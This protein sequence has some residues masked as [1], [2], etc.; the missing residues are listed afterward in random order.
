MGT[1]LTAVGKHATACS[2]LFCYQGLLVCIWESHEPLATLESQT[3]C[4]LVPYKDS[5][6]AEVRKIYWGQPSL[7]GG[8]VDVPQIME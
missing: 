6:I 2:Y 5:K 8:I 4:A 3:H 1:L 7:P